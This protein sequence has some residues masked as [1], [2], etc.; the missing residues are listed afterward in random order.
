MTYLPAI[1]QSKRFLSVI[2]LLIFELVVLWIPGIEAFR[3]QVLEAGTLALLAL[4]ASFTGQDWIAAAR[5]TATKYY[6]P[7]TPKG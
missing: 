2:V 6:D 7:N 1:F 5:G 4:V 3:E